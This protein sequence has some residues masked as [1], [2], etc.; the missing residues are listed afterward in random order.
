MNDHRFHLCHFIDRVFWSF[1]AQATILDPAIGHQIRS[2]EWP[3][4]DVHVATIDLLGK[5]DSSINILRKDTGTQAEIAVVGHF[6]G[7]ISIAS[8]TNSDRWSKQL[9]FDNF[10]F[11]SS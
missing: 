3:T 10:H 7:I 1:F 5:S 9:I 11:F 6:D 8:R 2:P 4:I